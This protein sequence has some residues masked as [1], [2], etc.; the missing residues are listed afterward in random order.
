MSIAYRRQSA[1]LSVVILLA[2][3]VFAQPEI[4]RAETGIEAGV[5]LGYGV[6][7]GGLAGEADL[8][9]GVSGQ[10]PIWID[11][12]YRPID[13]LMIGLY[14]QYGLA[15]MGGQFDDACDI[16]GVDC[17]ASDLRLGLQAHYH[18]SPQEQLDPWIG[19]GFGYEWLNLSVEGMGTEISIGVDG[20]E[21]L[22]L[23]AGLDIEVAEH[24]KI[25][26]VLTLTVAQFSNASLDCAGSPACNLFGSPDGDIEDTAVHEWLMI[27]VRGA[28]TP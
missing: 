4:A 17:S 20:F 11:L 13:A 1:W 6:P 15:F 12:G 18:I 21:F 8:S 24:F 9:D 14:F 7:L 22:N 10:I 27:G 26:P 28:Y 23:Q 25:G 19:I 16:D 5:R 3:G 2:S